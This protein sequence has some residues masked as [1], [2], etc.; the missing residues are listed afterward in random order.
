M[1]Q[2][3]GKP[4]ELDDIWQTWYLVYRR[5]Y[6]K[7]ALENAQ[8]IKKQFYHYQ[9]PN[10]LQVNIKITSYHKYKENNKKKKNHELKLQ[11]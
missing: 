4:C 1:K 3:N 9:E 2:N 8:N 7:I 11:Y 5:H 6:F 10:G